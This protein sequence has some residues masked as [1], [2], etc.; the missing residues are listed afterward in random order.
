[1]KCPKREK[2]AFVPGLFTPIKAQKHL[3]DY[4]QINSRLNY[5]RETE[6]QKGK[7]LFSQT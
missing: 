3:Q 4:P 7:F 2:D 5:V 1:M 6:K